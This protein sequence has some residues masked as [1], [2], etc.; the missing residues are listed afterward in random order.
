VHV[1]I[2]EFKIYKPPENKRHAVNGIDM[3]I[4][5]LLRDIPLCIGVL[6]ITG[7]WVCYVVFLVA[8][9]EI[10]K[11]SDD[12][13]FINM[14]YAICAVG[15]TLVAYMAT[16]QHLQGHENPDTSASLCTPNA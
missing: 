3:N 9:P 4:S 6:I 8:H 10:L 12:M 7:L 13:F 15:T 2:P 1:G 11:I 5:L 14:R 16:V